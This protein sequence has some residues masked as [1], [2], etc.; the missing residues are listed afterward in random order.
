M[1]K[2]G[3]LDL[4]NKIQL[5]AEDLHCA[6]A[7]IAAESIVEENLKSE[8][9]AELREVSARMAKAVKLEKY[10]AAQGLFERKDKLFAKIAEMKKSPRIR[11]RY[12][13]LVKSLETREQ[14]T[15]QVVLDLTQPATCIW[16]DDTIYIVLP[17]QLQKVIQRGIIENPNSWTDTMMKAKNVLRYLTLHEL[18]HI[19]APEASDAEA[20]DFSHELMKRRDL[21]EK[22][23]S[24]NDI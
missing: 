3:I 4:V 8:M 14:H 6:S 9:E 16:D 10:E 5:I 12:A 17:R 24:L 15:E 20:S 19:V 18:G 11:I 1:N 2:K 13:P 23:R 21:R 7:I 22:A